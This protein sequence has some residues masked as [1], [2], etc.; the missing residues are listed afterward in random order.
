MAVLL[1]ADVAGEGLGLDATAKAVSAVAPLGEVTV[2]VAGPRAAAEE[3]ARIAGVARVLLAED[4]GH[5]LA[6]PMAALVQGLAAG[7]SHVAAPST[8]DAKNILP[9]VASLLDGTVSWRVSA[10]LD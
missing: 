7:F 2:L 6:E 3:A 8:S 10:M 9:R 5:R 4:A 1:I